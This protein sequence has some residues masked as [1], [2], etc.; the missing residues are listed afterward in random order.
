MSILKERFIKRW[1][2][3]DGRDPKEDFLEPL[4]DEEQ[5]LIGDGFGSRFGITGLLLFFGLDFGKPVRFAQPS[6]SCLRR[7]SFL[8][9]MLLQ[10]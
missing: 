5:D 7:V 6:S 2:S 10:R 1:A 8:A 4:L 3:I 9:N